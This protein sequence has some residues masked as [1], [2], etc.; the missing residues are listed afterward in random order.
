MTLAHLISLAVT[1]SMAGLLLAVALRTDFDDLTYLLRQ[2]SL[3][4][5]SVLAMNV[6][7]PL[8]ALALMLAAS[9]HLQRAVEV[10]LVAMALGPVPPILPRKELKA[11]GARSYTMGLLASSAVVS[12][13]FVPLAAALLG[14]M[15]HKSVD[16]SVANVASIVATWMLLPLLIGATVRKLAP[17]LADSLAKPIRLASSGL[18]VLAFL[19]VLV[20][21]WPKMLAL[22]GNFTLVAIVAFVLVGLAVGHLLGGPDP[23]D[24]T[25]L[26]L[27][28]ATRHPAVAMAILHG[29]PD[30]SSAFAAV[31]LVLIVGGIASAPYSKWRARVRAGVSTPT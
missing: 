10:A 7:M 17:H 16:V 5:R 15:F 29:D 23:E 31:L 26:A 19:P 3:L 22:V 1:V 13:F 28:T 24:R 6:I 8:F 18:L 27:S 2:P 9:I 4:V 30:P 21:E 20:K 11:G 12:I 25:V 14:D